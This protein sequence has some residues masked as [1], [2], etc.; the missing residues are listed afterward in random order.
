MLDTWILDNCDWIL[1]LGFW[2]LI[3]FCSSINGAKTVTIYP[4]IILS[5]LLPFIFLLF[6]HLLI[7]TFW[8]S[9][10]HAL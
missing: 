1:A 2:F 4:H 7:Y 3:I 5:I 9:G 6:S 10:I 8:N